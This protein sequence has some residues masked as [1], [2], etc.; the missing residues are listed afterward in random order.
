MTLNKIEGQSLTT[1]EVPLNMTKNIH[2]AT[3]NFEQYIGRLRALEKNETSALSLQKH[4]DTS[5]FVTTSTLISVFA[6]IFSDHLL[7]LKLRSLKWLFLS[8]HFY[9][10]LS[11]FGDVS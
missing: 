6:K 9:K 2:T 8:I 5:I 10:I 11:I 1:T 7:I 4:Y 3:L